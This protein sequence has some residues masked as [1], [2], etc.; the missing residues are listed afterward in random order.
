MY[1]LPVIIIGALWYKNSFKVPGNG[2]LQVSAK[3][4]PDTALQLGE[5]SVSL[6]II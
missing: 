5:I 2:L 4:L 6:T 3:G 1:K